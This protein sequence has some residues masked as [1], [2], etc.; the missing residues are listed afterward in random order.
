MPDH[1]QRNWHSDWP[2]DFE[3]AKHQGVVSAPFQDCAMAFSS[4]WYLSGTDPDNAG[5]HL[6]PRSHLDRRNPRNPDDGIHDLLPIPG[7]VQVT[8]PPGSV[9]LQD[10]CVRRPP[11]LHLRNR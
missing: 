5:T 10:S 2:H 3:A 11:P 1:V 9:M 8:A 4:V 7:E 6:V